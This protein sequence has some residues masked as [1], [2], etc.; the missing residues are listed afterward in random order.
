[1]DTRITS[2]RLILIGRPIVWNTSW[3]IAAR[4]RL[5]SVYTESIESM[6][7]HVCVVERPDEIYL[8]C[9]SGRGDY[10]HEGGA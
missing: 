4:V 8:Y 1:M 3:A 6:R 7:I 5:S 2:L 9:R 10:L